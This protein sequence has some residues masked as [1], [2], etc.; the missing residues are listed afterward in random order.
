[1]TGRVPEPAEAGGTGGSWATLAE[2]TGDTVGSFDGGV[3]AV[4][5]VVTGTAAATTVV[6]AAAGDVVAGSVL[7]GA[8]VAGSVLAGDVLAGDV[9]AG[10]GAEVA[11]EAHTG[12]ELVPVSKLHP[13]APVGSSN[14]D[15]LTRHV[16]VTFGSPKENDALV[17]APKAV[18]A[19]SAP[20]IHTL[21]VFTPSAL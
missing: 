5:Y 7:A 8:V 12:I 2:T 3:A 11:A 14:A 1:M 10:A 20:S 17:D 13:F 18:L 4:G 21:T 16:C 9:L 15:T 6:A 19:R